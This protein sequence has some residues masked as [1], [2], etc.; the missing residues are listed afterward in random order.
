MV[1]SVPLVDAALEDASGD[2]PGDALDDAPEGAACISAL[3]KLLESG[4]LKA[5]DRIVIYNTGSGLKYPEAYST[6]F[7]RATAGEQDKLGGL[8]TPR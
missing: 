8:I 1:G 3:R 6:R 7:P 5:T 4:F 2:T